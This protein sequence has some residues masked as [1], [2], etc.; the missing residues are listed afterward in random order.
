MRKRRTTESIAVAVTAALV[1][2][3]IGYF[4][5]GREN[6]GPAQ[7]DSGST[8]E[9]VAAAAGARVLPT[10]PKLQVEPK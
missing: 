9:A 8:T 10:E 4:L 5:L 6:N 3:A 2:G 1:I 7:T